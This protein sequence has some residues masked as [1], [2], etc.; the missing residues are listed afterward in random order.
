M[1]SVACMYMYAYT[2]RVALQ[3]PACRRGL[4]L[5]ETTP[6]HSTTT[7][8]RHCRHVQTKA[9][10]SVGRAGGRSGPNHRPRP[11]ARQRAPVRLGATATD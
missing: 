10:S 8:A 5:T 4:P 3:L 1:M 11:R 9:K 7:R 6:T 2:T